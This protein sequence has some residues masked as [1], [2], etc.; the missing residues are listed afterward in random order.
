MA[1]KI[2]PRR[3]YRDDMCSRPANNDRS[4]IGKYAS[5]R[6]Y[7]RMG[8]KRGI[9]WDNDYARSDGNAEKIQRNRQK[10]RIRRIREKHQKYIPGVR[11][12]GN[13][14]LALDQAGGNVRGDE[15][16]QQHTARNI[17]GKNSGGCTFLHPDSNKLRTQKKTYKRLDSS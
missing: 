1:E 12:R 8:R 5:D 14:G 2:P 15:N 4:L 6:L 13:R 3:N 11:N 16:M 10:I 7:R 17:C 9:L